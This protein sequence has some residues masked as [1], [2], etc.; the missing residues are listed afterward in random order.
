MLG[1][2]CTKRNSHG[3][4]A[5]LCIMQKTTTLNYLFASKL[6]FGQSLNLNLLDPLNFMRRLE[7]LFQKETLFGS[8]TAIDFPWKT[9]IFHEVKG[10]LQLEKSADLVSFYLT[11][12]ISF[13]LLFPRIVA[14]Y[15]YP[16]EV[17]TKI[18]PELLIKYLLKWE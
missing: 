16:Q 7:L 14:M 18:T 4:S 11:Q 5:F 2:L 8:F 12:Q 10:I 1:C 15:I 9:G 6:K 17:S 13:S 3:Y